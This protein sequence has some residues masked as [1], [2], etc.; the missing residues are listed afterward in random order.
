MWHARC[1]IGFL[2]LARGAQTEQ[3]LRKTFVWIIP[4]LFRPFPVS[5]KKVSQFSRLSFALH[6]TYLVVLLL[7]SSKW[8]NRRSKT[9]MRE[10]ADGKFE[11]VSIISFFCSVYTLCVCFF[12]L[13]FD[14]HEKRRLKSPSSRRER[15]FCVILFWLVV[16]CV[17][18]TD[19]MCRHRTRYVNWTS[20]TR[21]KKR[22]RKK[23]DI[24]KRQMQ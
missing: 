17:M 24:K 20:S 10:R 4:T 8:K 16:L 2:L 15:F 22:R 13:R 18:Y 14:F 12:C 7:S 9:N 6:L 11:N 5:R 21:E 1:A 3:R 19:G 23:W